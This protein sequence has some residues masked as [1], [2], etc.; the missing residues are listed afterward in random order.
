MKVYKDMKKIKL[1]RIQIIFEIW[2]SGMAFPALL[3]KLYRFEIPFLTVN[4]VQKIFGRSEGRPWPHTP[5]NMLLCKR[6]LCR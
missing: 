3:S 6:V 4:L 1:E 5:L 2:V